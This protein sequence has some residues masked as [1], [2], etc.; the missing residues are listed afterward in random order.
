[1]YCVCVC[2]NCTVPSASTEASREIFKGTSGTICSPNYPQHYHNN[3]Y[4]QYEIVAPSLSKV[5]LT[6]VEFDL[7]YGDDCGYD[8]LKASNCHLTCSSLFTCP[9]H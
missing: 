7:E 8:S 3:E 6:F 1:M 5:V 2:G 9:R 4:K